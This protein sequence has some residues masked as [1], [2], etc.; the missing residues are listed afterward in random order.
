MPNIVDC[1]LKSWSPTST[2]NHISSQ[3]HLWFW[4]IFNILSSKHLPT[5]EINQN[6]GFLML[7][8]YVHTQNDYF[9][10]Q[11]VIFIS[12]KNIQKT[13]KNNNRHAL[14]ALR[15]AWFHG[16]PG[17]LRSPKGYGKLL[18]A[19]AQD[20]KGGIE[21][22]EPLSQRWRFWSLKVVEF[23]LNYTFLRHISTSATLNILNKF[24]S[25]IKQIAQVLFFHALIK[26]INLWC[27]QFT[28]LPTASRS[29]LRR[30]DARSVQVDLVGYGAL[31]D[32]CA[33]MGDA[34]RFCH[35]GKAEKTITN[36]LG[37]GVGRSF[38]DFCFFLVRVLKRMFKQRLAGTTAFAYAVQHLGG[39]GLYCQVGHWRGS[40]GCKRSS[41]A[42]RV[43]GTPIWWTSKSTW[44]LIS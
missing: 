24:Q 14:H 19:A 37:E 31:L 18:T 34:G 28:T 43:P 12:N 36:S 38:D 9:P 15:Q 44:A 4:D 20:P 25:S 26:L 29:L 10:H 7:S 17:G 23:L 32:G 35:F 27:L 5:D 16:I 1:I 21:V 8:S 6:W 33:A 41:C 30:A 11:K 42:T 40:N 13:T 2:R 3:N 39:L 22:V